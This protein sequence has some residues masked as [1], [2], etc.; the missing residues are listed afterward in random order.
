M[1]YGR[2]KQTARKVGYETC[3]ECPATLK[4]WAPNPNLTA[5]AGVYVKTS[6]PSRKFNGGR[7][8]YMNMDSDWK[9]APIYLFFMQDKMAWALGADYRVNYAFGFAG[10]EAQCPRDTKYWSFFNGNIQGFE[11]KHF[12]IQAHRNSNKAPKDTNH[13]AWNIHTRR[14]EREKI[15][16]EDGKLGA[17]ATQEE[18]DAA[19]GAESD[20]VE[21][22]TDAADSAAE[23]AAADSDSDNG[24][25]A[26]WKDD[27]DDSNATANIDADD[28]ETAD[29][30]A[31][32]KET[33]AASA[34]DDKFKD[35]EDDAPSG[36]EKDGDG[37][38]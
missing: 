12:N 6:L 37:V 35:E 38:E 22:A 10:M 18:A 20:A 16:W 28:K 32:D 33:V 7:P 30:D 3:Q 17:A 19:K 21:N 27:D 9:H 24:T 15:V 2:D 1:I 23:A 5:L 31:P 36:G 13:I 26:T 8:I 14:W 4:M 11:R 25:T 29:I 34:R